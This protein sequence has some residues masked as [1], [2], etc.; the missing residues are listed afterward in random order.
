MKYLIGLILFFSFGVM[1][2]IGPGLPIK[3]VDIQEIKDKAEYKRKC[4]TKVLGTNITNSSEGNLSDL[5]ITGLSPNTRYEANIHAYFLSVASAQHEL[6]VNRSNSDGSNISF[7]GQMRL[8][9]SGTAQ[10]HLE[11]G[12][13]MD[14]T[15]SATDDRVIVNFNINS[16]TNGTLVSNSTRLTVCEA[17]DQEDVSNF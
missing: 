16:G 14:F 6:R 1:A 15:T 9:S 13:I 7:I 17:D 12:K 2:Q 11:A 4:V 5:T 8:Y 10:N 3:A